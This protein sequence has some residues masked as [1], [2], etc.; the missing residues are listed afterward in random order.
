MEAEPFDCYNIMTLYL[1]AGIVEQ[2]EEVI[3]RQRRDKHFPTAP[4]QHA[5]IEEML[6]A[7]FLCDPRR[8]YRARASGNV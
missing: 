8:G 5:T 3:T 7:I 2:E 1:R 4:N 6:K